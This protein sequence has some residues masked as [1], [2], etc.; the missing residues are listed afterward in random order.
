MKNKMKSY[1]ALIRPL[2]WAPFLFPFLFGLIDAGFS[3][4]LLAY[5]SFLT[6]ILPLSG[7]YILNFY[8]DINADKFN[9]IKKDVKMSEQP[10]ITGE[11]KPLEGILLAIFLMVSGL[12]FSLTISMNLFLIVFALFLIGVVYSFP[13]RL[14]GVP[15]FDIFSNASSACLCYI[16]GWTLFRSIYEISVLPVIW[17]FLLMA[18]IYLLTVIIDIKGDKKA[19]I[20]TTAVCLGVR[21][22]IR[23]SFFIYMFSLFFYALILIYNMKL[24]Y[25]LLLPFFAKS[26]TTYYKLL[27]DP[28]LVYNVAK[29]AAVLSWMAVVLLILLYSLFAVFSIA[30]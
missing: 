19:G 16:A 29:K 5:F 6:I 26:I 22:S 10:F 12:Y 20:K 8:S 2:C 15:F 24:A 30:L 14:K 23:L 18:S 1:I 25:I 4:L 21:K 27:K 7:I 28:L 17:I 13:P 3:S 11:V 9:K